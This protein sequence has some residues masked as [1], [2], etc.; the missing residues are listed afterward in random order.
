MEGVR[1]WR[2]ACDEVVR[3]PEAEG[4]GAK[5][6]QGEAAR[7][8][9]DDAPSISTTETTET[10]LRARNGVGEGVPGQLNRFRA[11]EGVSVPSVVKTKTRKETET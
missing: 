9:S 3:L 5:R 7:F 4:R 8:R 10:A 6:S 11:A 1:D 2:C